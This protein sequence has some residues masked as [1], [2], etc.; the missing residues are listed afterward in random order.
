MTTTSSTDSEGG[1]HKQYDVILCGT[2][3][4]QSIVASALAR[5]GKTVLHCD[6]A[7]YY[8]QLDAVWTFPYLQ[9]LYSKD[10]NQNQAEGSITTSTTTTTTTT[11]STT[12]TTIPDTDDTTSCLVHYLTTQTDQTCLTFHSMHTKTDF[13]ILHIGTKVVTPYGMGCI[14]QLPQPPQQLTLSIALTNWTLTN[15]RHPRLFVSS[16]AAQIQTQAQVDA[17]TILQQHSRSLAFDITPVLVY[18]A[19]TAVDALLQSGVAEYLEWKA[20]EGLLYL[21]PQTQ[22]LDK[23]PCNKNDIFLSPT[24]GPM[25]KRRL[26][27]FLQLAM[28]YYGIAQQ[29]QPEHEHE[30]HESSVVTSLNE[31]H[32]NQ[33]R[34]LARPQNKAVQT[35]ELEALEQYM[36]MPFSTYLEEQQKLSPALISL[37]R[38]ALALEHGD[39]SVREGMRQLCQ[40]MGSLGR[41]GTTAFLVPLYGSGE[42]AQA[43]C[44]SAAVYG[45]TYMLRRTPLAVQIHET[46]SRVKGLWLAPMEEGAS[47]KLIS[48]SHVVVPAS[49]LKSS[50]KSESKVLR[51]IS[52]L[53]GK[54]ITEGQQRHAIIIPPSTLGSSSP[55]Y[56]LLLDETVNIVPRVPNG[57]TLVHLTTTVVGD[58]DASLLEKALE[59]ILADAKNDVEEIFQTCFS[60]DLYESEGPDSSIEGLHQVR[61]AAPG[62]EVDA[63]FEKAKEIFSRI[64]PNDE[65]LV[66]S[67]QLET[68]IKERLG[69][70]AD[71]DDD[72]KRVLESAIGILAETESKGHE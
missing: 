51:R 61:C 59:M 44:R 28:D 23:V 8:G 37:V 15:G 36:D 22:R 17:Q 16:P 42:L 62:L 63:A 25:D 9:Q 31:R 19:G 27:K 4:I 29:P 12:S 33:G 38:F 50:V 30:Q 41:F 70:H 34:S 64:C 14:E 69:D 7:D 2:G 32:L 65:F 11:T 18:A 60:Y 56:G 54:L 3:L 68:E 49:A 57:C 53:R 6:A 39:S 24:L 20:L 55:I 67:K 10:E 13:P 72:E 58:G 43:F 71:E 45:A 1:L 26:M 66:I 48:C 52:V 5:A 47:P 21:N 35:S 40:H 46:N